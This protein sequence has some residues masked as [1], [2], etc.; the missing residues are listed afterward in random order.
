MWR[1]AARS[2][3]RRAL[4]AATGPHRPVSGHWGYD[5]GQPIDR[6]YIEAFLDAHRADLRG[7]A[8]EVKSDTYVRRY[9]ASLSRVHVLDVD[10]A[11]SAAT[12]I[13]DLGGER[14]LPPESLDCF[15]LT[16]TLQYVW[17]LRAAV[18]NA[19][20]MLRPGGVL[21]L[22]VPSVA[23][24]STELDFD[25]LW[26]FTADS[27]RRLLVPAFGEGKVSI[28]SRGNL[29]AANA[30]LAGL[31]ASELSA[32][33]LDDDDERFPVVIAARAERG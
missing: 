27:M 19:H 32:R 24:I 11:N 30:F 31:A 22:T 6:W 8:L 3:R 4:L 15:V 17:D 14:P 2:L 29:V 28:V 1:D 13:G 25:D 18:E 33:E 9:G 16:Q 7:D 5:R 20:E 10:G 21:L 26:R 12:V 23:R